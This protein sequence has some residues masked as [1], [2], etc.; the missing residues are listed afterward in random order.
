MISEI[1]EWPRHPAD[2]SVV[3]NDNRLAVVVAEH[4]VA[5]A[6]VVE[7]VDNAIAAVLAAVA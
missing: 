1:P 4:D 6:V 3:G 7:G 2:M 5:A